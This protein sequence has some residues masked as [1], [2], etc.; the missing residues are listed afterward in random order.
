[1][2]TR[3]AS[4]GLG[5]PASRVDSDVGEVE[6]SFGCVMDADAAGCC[7]CGV[8]LKCLVTRV[9]M[10]GSTLLQPRA[11]ARKGWFQR[12]DDAS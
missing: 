9:R 7:T 12:R 5:G 3:E 4:L 10:F 8:G 2:L 11:T 1:M 6:I